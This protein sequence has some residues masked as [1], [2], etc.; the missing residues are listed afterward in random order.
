VELARKNSPYYASSDA[1][2]R[3]NEVAPGA[4][5]DLSCWP[6]LTRHDVKANLD[7]FVSRAHG[8]HSISHTSGSTGPALHVRRS[9]EEVKFLGGYYQALYRR[10]LAPLANTGVVRPLTLSFPNYY[11]GTP[12]PIPGIGFGFVSGVTDDV[13]IKDAL[14]LLQARHDIPG[15]ADRISLL[16]GLFHHISFF[17]SYILEQGIDPATLGLRAITLT[18]GY[19]APHWRSV[20]EDSWKATINDRFSLTEV[21]G[22]AIWCPL[23]R[24][25]HVDPILVGEVLDV[26]TLAPVKQGPGLLALTGLHPFMQMQPMI[27]YLTDDVVRRVD[28]SCPSALSFEFLGKLKNCHRIG[29]DWVLFSARLDDAASCLPDLKVH[30]LFSNV[31]AVHDRTVG[32]RAAYRARLVHG[33]GPPRLELDFELKYAPHC[34]RDRVRQLEVELTAR[35]RAVPG[36][37]L[38]DWLDRGDLELALRFV[39]PGQLDAPLVIKV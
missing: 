23:C 12:L 31:G 13:L 14:S 7:G 35:L 5:P 15:H 20:L 16:S 6:T 36:S 1:Y 34:Y 19:L 29:A 21:V 38:G 30:E 22:G 2:L 9:R 4:P 32:C 27:R 17:T 18:G 37:V 10:L 39:G 24:L 28:S 8:L 26:D 33:A 3:W 11:H 25:F